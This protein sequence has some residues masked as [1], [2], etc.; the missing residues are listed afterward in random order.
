MCKKRKLCF[1]KIAYE[2]FF[3][4]KYDL[5]VFT[6]IFYNNNVK[7]NLQLHSPAALILNHLSNSYEDTKNKAFAELI[8]N[9]QLN[10]N[11]TN[12]LFPTPIYLLAITAQSRCVYVVNA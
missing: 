7:I 9:Q 1:L 11:Y 2:C 5:L 10:P 4:C 6:H 8:Y 12:S 3:V